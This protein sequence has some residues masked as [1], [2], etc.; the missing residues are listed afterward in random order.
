M[1]PK[2]AEAT[3]EGLGRQPSVYDMTLLAYDDA[4]LIEELRTRGYLVSPRHPKV[5]DDT[6]LITHIDAALAVY[7]LRPS[8]YPKR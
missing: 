5:T 1:P 4:A 2:W 7:G 6:G 8:V 3:P